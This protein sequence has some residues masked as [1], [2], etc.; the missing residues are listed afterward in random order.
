MKRLINHRHHPVCSSIMCLSRVAGLPAGEP[1]PL[2]GRTTGVRCLITTPDVFGAD[3]ESC[4]GF[5]VQWEQYFG[6]QPLLPDHTKVAFVISRLTGSARA[7]GAYLVVN[8]SPLLN[9][10]P[11]AHR[12]IFEWTES[13]TT[14]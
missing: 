9:D 11:G 10:Y 13:R 14:G 3:T 1:R 12:R 2:A 7:W 6:Y 4:K 8:S 5:V